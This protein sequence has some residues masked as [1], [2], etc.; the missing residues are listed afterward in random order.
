MR[1]FSAELVEHGE[2]FQ[3]AAEEAQRRAQFDGLHMV[4]S[5][6][7]DLVLGVATYALE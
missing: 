4:P 5:F 1:A 7:P 2:D 6:H 3:A